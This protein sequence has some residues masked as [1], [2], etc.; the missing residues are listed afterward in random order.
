MGHKIVTMESF[1]SVSI[2]ET[3][4]SVRERLGKPY[5][6]KKEEN[7]RVEYVYIE[8]IYG[9]T[10]NQE[11]R[12][13]RIFFKEGKVVEKKISSESPGVFQR[14]SIDIQTSANF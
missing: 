3:C 11:E 10:M 12:H 5:L 7:G 2:G 13:Y 14:N 9:N 6:V 1:S 8:R 4:E